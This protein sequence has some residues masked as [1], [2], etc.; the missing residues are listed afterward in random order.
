MGPNLSANVPLRANI[1]TRAAEALAAMIGR[2]SSVQVTLT[3]RLPIAAGLGGGSADA[4]AVLRL[5]NRLWELQLADAQLAEIGVRLGADVPMCL[6]QQPLL[7]SGIGEQV[8]PFSGMPA[9]PV[10]LACP[11]VSVSTAAVFAALAADRP[12][13]GLPPL[14]ARFGAPADVAGWLRQTRNDL[15]APAAEV[16]RHAA[17]AAEALGSDAGCL[18]ARMSGSG[19]A[20]FGI[21]PSRTAAERAAARLRAAHPDW[22]VAAT[23]TG[24]S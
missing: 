12:V 9:L 19:A 1:V 15:A 21:F 17:D 6:V 10:V 4:A 18:F 2:G 24:G 13:A 11:P 16:D 8:A 14:P 5:L 23:L 20:A 3:K 22:W 7:A